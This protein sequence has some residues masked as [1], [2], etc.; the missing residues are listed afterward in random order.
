[1]WPAVKVAIQ[2]NSVNLGEVL[3]DDSVKLEQVPEHEE[4]ILLLVL[5][6]TSPGYGDHL[7]SSA[8][9]TQKVGWI[10]CEIA[11]AIVCIMFWPAAEPAME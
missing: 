10:E 1:M 8:A 2:K 9:E 7:V 6:N 5:T 4:L 11:K 3:P